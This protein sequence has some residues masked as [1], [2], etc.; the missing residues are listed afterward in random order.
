MLKKHQFDFIQDTA[1]IFRLLLDSFAYPGKKNDVL[2]YSGK[3]SANHSV[4]SALAVVLLDNETSFY[5]HGA[6][7][8]AQEVRELT[9][10]PASPAEKAYFIFV[11]CATDTNEKRFLLRDCL[12]GSFLDPHESATI[13]VSVAS[14]NERRVE[15]SG[16]G[17]GSGKKATFPEEVLDWMRERDS[18]NFEYPLG[19]D[20]VFVLSDSHVLCVPRLV[21]VVY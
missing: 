14:G 13:L 3:L 10:C 12:H 20:F 2:P 15:L 17:V 9:N 18:Q 6:P 1:N 19:V 4:M 5:V 7:E 11:P 21:K 16:P 8:L